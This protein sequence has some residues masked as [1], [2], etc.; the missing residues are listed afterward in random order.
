MKRTATRLLSSPGTFNHV[1][2]G[3]FDSG[4]WLAVM[5]DTTIQ[6]PTELRKRLKD[7][8]LP[9]ESNYGDTIERLLG[10]STGG[11][12]WTEQ[13]LKDLVDRRIELA[14]RH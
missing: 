7:K 5:S 9:H 3:R 10:D 14:Q 6:I 13:E 4:P 12:L 1:G 2:V 8:R 11:Q